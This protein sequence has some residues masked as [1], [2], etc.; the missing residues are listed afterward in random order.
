M[1][2]WCETAS[3]YSVDKEHVAFNFGT[4]NHNDVAKLVASKIRDDEDVADL[5]RSGICKYHDFLARR[6][7]AR[8]ASTKLLSGCPEGDPSR[9]LSCR[10]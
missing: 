2:D 3:F 4:F 6:G 8:S 7:E 9:V 1:R 5:V 10:R